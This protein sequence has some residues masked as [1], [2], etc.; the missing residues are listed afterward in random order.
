MKKFLI[1]ALCC[2]LAGCA[3]SIP[4]KS[5]APTDPNAIKVVNDLP[6][7]AE[8]LQRVEAT[9]C[10]SNPIGK[11]PGAGLVLADLKKQAAQIGATG[12]YKVRYSATGLLQKCVTLP[13]RMATGIAF[14]ADL[15]KS[16]YE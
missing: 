13:G 2:F 12:I 16:V 7:N 4:K 8:L 11:A 5:Y 6:N 14:R 15:Q 9:A 3:A 10:S 1:A